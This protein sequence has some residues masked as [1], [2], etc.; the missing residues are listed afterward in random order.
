MPTQPALIDSNRSSHVLGD[1][2]VGQQRLGVGLVLALLGAP[3][4]RRDEPILVT[5]VQKYHQLL[6]HDH[7]LS[8]FPWSLSRT[9]GVLSSTLLTN[10]RR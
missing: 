5:A 8:I 6:L 9:T 2:P 4:S 1:R 3:R 10:L 7:D